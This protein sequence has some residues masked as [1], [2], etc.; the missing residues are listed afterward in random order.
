MKMEKETYKK[1]CRRA[2]AALSDGEE[3]SVRI[4][5]RGWDL[6]VEAGLARY[7]FTPVSQE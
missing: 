4:S 5:D 6:H 2:R 1:V 7:F 3:L